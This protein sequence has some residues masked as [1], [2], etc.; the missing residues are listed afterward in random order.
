M[1]Y[2]S[3][4]LHRP[5]PWWPSWTPGSM[6]VKDRHEYKTPEFE[7]SREPGDCVYV[8]RQ[9]AELDAGE[10]VPFESSERCEVPA[11]NVKCAVRREVE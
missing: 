11:A 10:W 1:N 7:I 9:V 8:V 4:H 6:K 5:A 3:I 2:Q